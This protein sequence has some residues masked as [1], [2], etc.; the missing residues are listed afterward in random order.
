[1]EQLVAEPTSVRPARHGEGP[2]WDD[3]DGEL[4]WV[5]TAAGE[6][7]WAR[8][9]ASG[10]VHDRAMR[11]VGEPVGAV[12]PTTSLGWL[13]AAGGGFR[14]LT[15]EGDVSV[16]LELAG[17]GGQRTRMNDGACD[18]A[19]R[20]F[21]GTMTLHAQSGA[22]SLYR[23]DLDGIVTTVLSG[24]TVSNGIAWSP[25]D[26]VLYLVDSGA[27]TVTAYDYDVDLGT[28]GRSRVLLHLA[29]DD[30]PGTPDGLT[31][32]R[33]GHLWI[34]LWGGGQVRRYSAGGI[35]EEVVRVPASQTSSCTFAGPLLDTLVVS[36]SA[37]GLSAKERAVQPDAGRLFT[38][39]VPD[40]RGRPAFPYRGP[41][42]SL[43]QA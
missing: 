12:T 42:R 40:V 31:V 3:R 4:L 32:D 21:A 6:V 23:V 41:L 11:S 29:D 33:E 19:G 5:D 37:E 17:E 16:L 1:V 15:P 30:V 18:R 24:L 27:R 9:E 14:G 36:T 34:A 35:P 26:D 2:V 22:A 38:A 20:F 39:R 43:T 25:D 10:T 8:L 13:L 7:R 28:L